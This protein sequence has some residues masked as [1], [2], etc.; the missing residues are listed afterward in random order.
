MN[1]ASKMK[2]LHT[3]SRLLRVCLT[4]TVRLL[5]CIFILFLRHT[6]L[7]MLVTRSFSFFLLACVCVML[8]MFSDASIAVN[9]TLNSR[10]RIHIAVVEIIFGPNIF[11]SSFKFIRCVSWSE[12]TSTCIRPINN[13]NNGC[14]RTAVIVLFN[15]QMTIFGWRVDREL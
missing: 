5:F 14:V 1:R 12:I 7:E 9:H 15:Q 2:N 11:V 6:G 10:S 3:E 13:R 4:H 8:F